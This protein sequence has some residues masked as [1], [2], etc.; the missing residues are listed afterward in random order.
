MKTNRDQLKFLDNYVSMIE[1]TDILSNKLL[2]KVK[3]GIVTYAQKSAETTLIKTIQIEDKNENFSLLVDTKIL[4][5]FLTTLDLNEEFEIM[6]KGIDLGENK[7]YT[8]ESYKIDFPDIDALMDEISQKMED[9]F[10][11]FN[12][13]SKLNVIKYAG[14][15]SLSC[16]AIV[17]GNVITTD[18][19]QI[20][21]FSFEGEVPNEDSYF[22]S[23]KAILLLMKQKESIPI[24]VQD[25]YYFFKTSDII[26]IFN[27]IKY[28]IPDKIFQSPYVDSFNQS[29]FISVEK[30]KL[31]KVLERMS[32][33]VKDNPAN[34]LH[35]H[36][37]KDSLI[38]ENKDFNRSSEKIE[39]LDTNENLISDSII[40]INC[41]NILSFIISLKGDKI[42]FYLNKDN[43]S[44]KTIRFEDENHDL[45]FVHSRLKED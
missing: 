15:D 31:K 5:D 19:I 35:L 23:K 40:L 25:K 39:L 2:I 13:L 10:I 22:F 44:R 9:K 41:L 43:E 17:S 37:T 42:Y 7:N 6:E 3:D 33:F 8:F 45:K 26:C 28:S 11:K 38:I 14:K 18:K 29:D 30:T 32:F 21:Y 16:L 36:I 1:N 20:A 27:K 4:Y 24:Y 12:D 34:R